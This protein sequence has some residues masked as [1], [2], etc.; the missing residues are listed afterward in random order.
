MNSN[1]TVAECITDAPH[2][3]LRRGQ[4]PLTP[5]KDPF[6]QPPKGY[7]LGQPG[8]VLRSREVELAFLG[9]ILQRITATQ[10]LYR[11]TNLHGEPEVAVT[12]VLVP[13]ERDPELMCPVLSYQCAID[14]VASRCFPS[15]A[16]RRGARSIG[17]FVQSEFL[18]VAAALAEGWAVSVPATT[19]AATV[20]G[21]RRMSPDTG[22]S[23]ACAPPC[24]ASD[25]D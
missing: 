18:L 20:C 23:T 5:D 13:A 15:Y 22:F 21:A 2:E 3:R 17:A 16:L 14:A 24:N 19:R 10:L 25:W 12:T 11:S 8:A 4:R 7:E 1:S 6:Y 9:V